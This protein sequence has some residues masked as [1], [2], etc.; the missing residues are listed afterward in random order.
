MKIDLASKILSRSRIAIW[1]DSPV[2]WAH[3]CLNVKLTGYQAE[4]LDALPARRRV[5]VKG[6]HGLGKV[7]RGRSW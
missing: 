7:S 1:R 2:A 3:D 4:I 6:P 5:A